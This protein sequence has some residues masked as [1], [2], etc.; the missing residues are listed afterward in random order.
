MFEQQ[1]LKTA[2]ETQSL[3]K[4]PQLP[5]ETRYRTTP[6]RKQLRANTTSGRNEQS[7]PR[8][9]KDKR[10]KSLD[11]SPAREEED[12]GSKY[13]SDWR[14]SRAESMKCEVRIEDR[15][16]TEIRSPDGRT[17]H[18]RRRRLRWQPRPGTLQM[19][20]RSNPTCVGGCEQKR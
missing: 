17:Q 18:R 13:G 6:R 5:V 20:G 16:E 14:A 8:L 2:N 3:N 7:P 11:G 4:T 1:G 10:Q 9:S 19:S 15:A 12:A